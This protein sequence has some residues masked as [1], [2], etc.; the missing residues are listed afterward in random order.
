MESRYNTVLE[1]AVGYALKWGDREYL[2]GRPLL[3]TAEEVLHFSGWGLIK[4]TDYDF[5]KPK[6]RGRP[7]K[8]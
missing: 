5:G 1:G 2:A 4:E 3:L 6:Q 7:K 8:K